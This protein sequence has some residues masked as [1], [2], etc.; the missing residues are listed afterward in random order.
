VQRLGQ[1]AASVS[2]EEEHGRVELEQGAGQESAIWNVALDPAL[3]NPEGHQ[4]HDRQAR[5]DRE[6]F[7]V[8]GF[9]VGVLRHVAGGD[10]EAGEAREAGEY[11]AGEEQLV[12]GG[13]HAGGEGG[14]RGRD[15]EGDLVGVC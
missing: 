9:A 5:G 6:A 15:A 1:H 2:Q 4:A 11:E 14:D 7:K 13:A 3:G 10:V 12:E 8:L